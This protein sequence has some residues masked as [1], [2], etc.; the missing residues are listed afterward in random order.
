MGQGTFFEVKADR[1]HKASFFLQSN[2]A[3]AWV[4]IF[5]AQKVWQFDI[6]SE[7]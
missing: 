5:V 7:R 4:R 2:I 6:N 3:I 1:Y